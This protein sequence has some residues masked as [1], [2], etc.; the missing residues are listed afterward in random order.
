MANPGY[1]FVVN[2]G[3]LLAGFPFNYVEKLS[4]PTIEEL[5][6]DTQMKSEVF[7]QVK[8]VHY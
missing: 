2:P 1:L 5:Q 6:K 4:D 8:N 7:G 3:Q